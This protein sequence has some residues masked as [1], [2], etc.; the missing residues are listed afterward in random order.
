M[1]RSVPI[2]T[3]K[4]MERK[5]VAVVLFFG[6]IVCSADT[7]KYYWKS[8]QQMTALKLGLANEVEYYMTSGS[9][10]DCGAAPADPSDLRTGFPFDDVCNDSDN[11]EEE[12]CMCVMKTDGS[13]LFA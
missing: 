10:D 11:F 13:G 7:Y 2:W 12:T 9:E 5:A 3:A 1:G 8:S 6:T 4:M